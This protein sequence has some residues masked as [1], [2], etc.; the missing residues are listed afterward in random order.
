MLI[1]NINK[2]I[3]IY[4][5]YLPIENYRAFIN[6]GGNSSSIGMGGVEKDTMR[7]GVIFPI[8][9]NDMI[10]ENNNFKNSIANHFLNNDVVFINIKN[11]Y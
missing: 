7:V 9:R 10:E 5:Q 2:K 4:G 1:K 11:I 6:I 3:G 8:E